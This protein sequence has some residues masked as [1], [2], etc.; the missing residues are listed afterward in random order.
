MDYDLLAQELFFAMVEAARQPFHR[1][2]AEFARGELNIL[3]CLCSGQGGATSG[4]L[5]GRVGLGSGRMADALKSLEEKNLIDR[6]GD[7]A[8]RRRVIV[9][10]TDDGRTLVRDKR[11]LVLGQLRRTLAGLGEQDAREF[12]RLMKR[13]VELDQGSPPGP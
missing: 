10:I 9:S 8:D 11:T 12:V 2:P 7:A 13:I 5:G 4:E 3:S 6:S 1:D